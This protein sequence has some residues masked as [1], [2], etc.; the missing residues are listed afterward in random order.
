MKILN[1]KKVTFFLL[2]FF[3][4]LCPLTVK[5]TNANVS[6]SGNSS[7]YNGNTIDITLVISESGSKN[8][9]GISGIQGP[10]S[11]DTS[12]LELI[13]TKSHSLNVNYNSGKIVGMVTS[14]AEYLRGT[15]N[16]ITFTFK[17]K[18]LGSANVS[19]KA[20][21]SDADGKKIFSNTVSKTISITNPPSSNNNLS[22]LSVSNSS[23]NF[24]KNNTNYSV[25]VD[26]NVTNITIS[27][28]S[29][30]SGASIT[31]I[32]TKN[33]N[34]GNNQFYIVVTAPSGDKKT[35][36]ITV[37]RKDNRS[38]NNKLASLSVNGAELSPKF[39]ANTDSYSVSVPYSI[40]N[41]KVNAK[42]ED[43]KAKINI[44]NTNLTA[45]GTTDVKIVVTAENGST[46]TYTIHA[47]RGKDP[48]KVL[49]TNNNLSSLTVST[50]TLSPSFN[51]DQTKYIIYLPYE[52]D[53]I[54]FETV[55]E[56]IKYAKVKIEGPNKLNVGNNNYKILVTA[57]D[58]S[59]KEYTVIV[60]RGNNL[61]ETTL[62]SNTN[63][64]EIKFK[65][66][67]LVGK[68]DS[69]K[70]EYSYK[71]YKNFKIEKVVLEDENSTV[72]IIEE[73][74]TIYLLV[75]SASGEY[76]IYT[77][78]VQEFSVMNIIV[79]L[80]IFLLGMVFGISITLFMKKVLKKKKDNSENESEM[81]PKT[82]KK[83]LKTRKEIKQTKVDA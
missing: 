54:Q 48:N 9:E 14:Q 46:K 55:V 20:D 2:S 34:Y 45:E 59:I 65:N 28:T 29:E 23:I 4:F 3:L 27:A 41:L 69:T 24:N 58:N 31:G 60:A 10:I 67:S 39:N 16:V 7:V 73:G 40:S 75:T 77:L 25:S 35:Y 53:S 8:D 44:T 49:S 33:L 72:N 78:R 13:S 15:K 74:K 51:K 61:L 1:T 36:A 71:K 50:G 56:D 38:G 68:I 52:V 66:G 83:K 62:S 42:T 32:G 6:F 37:N 76:D 18:A 12:K 80:L 43:E 79:Y 64:K 17:A 30:D 26:S 47:T 57:E 63:I 70:R 5:A 82:K 21:V 81:K 22:S 11:Y 19:I